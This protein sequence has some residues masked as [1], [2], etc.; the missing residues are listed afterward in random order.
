[1]LIRAGDEAETCRDET[2]LPQVPWGSGQGLNQITMATVATSYCNLPEAK[3][4][5]ATDPQSTCKAG[6][7][8]TLVADEET[9]IEEEGVSQLLG[10][11]APTPGPRCC[12][13]GWPWSSDPNL[14]LISI[15][16]TLRPGRSW[17]LPFFT[18]L[19]P[20]PSPLKASGCSR[21]SVRESDE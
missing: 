17:R 10:H 21:K 19:A 14:G 12:S 6:T 1:M 11:P 4:H 15:A 20:P 16:L 5:S 2:A 13:G 9:E 18:P 7:V 8:H 3:P